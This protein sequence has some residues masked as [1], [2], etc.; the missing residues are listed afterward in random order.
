MSYIPHTD[1]D[2]KEM[3][4]V[5]GIKAVH[6]LFNAIP[7]D[8][9][10]KTPLNLPNELPEQELVREITNISRKNGNIEDYISFIGAGAYN[11]YV[12]S[13]VHHIILRSE[14]YTAYTPY[15]P[16]ISQGTLQAIF[17]Y[18]T[19]ICQLTGMDVTNASMYDGASAS[20]EAVLMAQRINS[21]PE[22][23]LSSALHPEYREVVKTYLGIRRDSIKEI[24]FCTETGATPVEAVERYIDKDTACV[25]IQ[26]P[27]FFGS[28]ED[29]SAI[30]EIV[31]KNGSVFIVV[32]TEPIS[33]GLLK[34]PGAFDADI[35][36]GEGQA[37]GSALNLGGPYLGFFATKEG[38][39]RNMPG[40]LVGETIDKDGKR[41][42]I[43]TLATREQH[44][45]REKAT[46]NI[47]TNEGLCA[48]TAAIYLTA[49]GKTGIV[50]LAKINLCKMHYLRQRLK[51]LK[52]VKPAFSS[53]VFNEC[54][55]NLNEDGDT[56]IKSLLKQGILG[57]ISLKRFYPQLN[58]HILLC[59]TEMNTKEDIDMLIEELKELKNE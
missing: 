2:I 24:P 16:E 28:I 45:R 43:L 22:C 31:H 56:V 25:V 54:V 37:F 14:F 15:Q 23:L 51:E 35:V 18:Q 12:P 58:S 34:P 11:H 29:L 10:L 59:A 33:L 17:E 6:D 3:L 48:L 19:L 21:R 40:R 32:I 27:N 41:G 47:C 20:A 39:L 55:I 13:I 50:N 9:R 44:I 26:Y 38:F 42:Y 57:G 4:G 36:V 5:I 1:N 8:I 52:N 53:P 46:S 7:P 30:S 49:L